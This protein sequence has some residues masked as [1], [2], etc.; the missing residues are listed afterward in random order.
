MHRRIAVVITVIVSTLAAALTAAPASAATGAVQIYAPATVALDEGPATLLAAVDEEPCCGQSVTYAWDLDNDGAYDDATGDRTEWDPT[1]WATGPGQRTVRVLAAV[2]G[3]S[4][5]ASSTITVIRSSSPFT[6]VLQS[7]MSAATTGTAV[8]FWATTTN[9][10]SG[11]VLTYGWDLDADG[12]F[13][14]VADPGQGY[15]SLAWDQPGSHVVT[16]RARH[17]QMGD[18]PWAISSTTVVVTVPVTLTDPTL[19]GIARVGQRLTATGATASPGNAVRTWEWLRDGTVVAT[20]GV[21]SYVLTTGDAGRRISVRVRAALAGH[22]PGTSVVSNALAVAAHN[23]ARPSITG[24]ARVGRRLTGRPGSWVAPGHTRSFQWL[25]DGRVIRGATRSS[26]VVA[27]GDRGHRISLRVT[28][29]RAGF[30]V[31]SAVSAA[32]PRV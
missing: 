30:P 28:M 7:L 16:V 4:F 5:V 13:D 8:G 12:D 19:T 23:T 1:R 24:V 18:D 14:D 2:D 15:V 32:L 21:A 10:P 6:L 22:Q 17:D 11:S 31:V 3:A 20:T 27:R 29:R 26:Y 25:R 9:A